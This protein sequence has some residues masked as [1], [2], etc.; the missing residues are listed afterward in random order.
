MYSLA[1]SRITIKRGTVPDEN[2]DPVPADNVVYQGIADIQFT[3]NRYFD[4]ATQTP[5]TVRSYDMAIGSNANILA[6]DFLHD[7]TNNLDYIVLDV[8]KSFGPLL[9][10]DLTCNLKRVN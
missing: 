10:D 4:K 8:A 1:T 6:G 3:S 5:R 2:G 7:D 9:T